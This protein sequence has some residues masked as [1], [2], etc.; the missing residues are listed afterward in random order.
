MILKDGYR[1]EVSM[2]RLTLQGNLKKYF[3][4]NDP[5]EKPMMEVY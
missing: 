2:M 3:A 4:M 5:G 1:K